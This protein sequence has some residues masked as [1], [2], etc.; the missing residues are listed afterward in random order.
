MTVNALK[1]QRT[2]RVSITKIKL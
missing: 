1:S 2:Q